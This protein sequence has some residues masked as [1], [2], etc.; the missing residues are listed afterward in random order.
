M[1][2]TP[3]RAAHYSRRALGWV[4]LACGILLFSVHYLAGCSLLALAAVTLYY[5]PRWDLRIETSESAIRFSENVLEVL[6]V[7]LAL[8]DILEIRRVA[9]REDR[10]GLL[11]AYPAYHAFVEFETRAGRIYRMHDIFPETFDEEVMRL[12]AGAG[13]RLEDF[14][15]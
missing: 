5:A 9:E 7:E 3:V 10:K 14:P 15:R 11:A 1:V 4:F 2:H 6:P 13:I 8:A 12:G